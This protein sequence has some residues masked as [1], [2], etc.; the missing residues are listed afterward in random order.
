MIRLCTLLL[1]LLTVSLSSSPA[2]AGLSISITS[3]PLNGIVPADWTNPDY[4]TFRGQPY[5]VSFDARSLLI[6]GQRVFLTAGSTHYPR[7]TPDMWP[8][9]FALFRAAGLNTLQ[10]IVFWSYH[11]LQPGQFDF[12]SES[13]DVLQFMQAAADAGLFIYLRLGPYICAE[14]SWGGMPYWLREDGGCKVRT[15]DPK[16]T[17]PATRWLDYI[18]KKLEPM[19]A[20]NGGPVIIFQL[21][22]EYG[23]VEA[24]YGQEGKQFLQ[25]NVDKAANLSLSV[26]LAMCSQMDAPQS[27]LSTYNGWYADDWIPTFR[28]AYPNRQTTIQH[29]AHTLY[30]R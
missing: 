30:R 1:L 14:Y 18:T 9:L 5:N 6:N 24:S 19:L 28:A 25:W 13:R 8:D 7:S 4:S 17:Q 20:R 21:E 22:N 27:V 29:T 26:P 11:E 10:M 3:P 12:S 15:V 2:Y 16:W 23:N